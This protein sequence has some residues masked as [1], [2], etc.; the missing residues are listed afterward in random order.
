M[1]FY[2]LTR[3]SLSLVVGRA[4]CFTTT[5]CDASHKI[6]VVGATGTTGL[7]AVQGL[8][9]VGYEPHQLKLV[10][11]D[12]TK[13]TI[14]ELKRLGFGIVQADLEKQSKLDDIGEGCNGCYIHSTSSD[15][16]ELD[17]KEVERAKNLCAAIQKSCIQRV[18]YNSAAASKDHGVARI[19][20]K[21]DVE[22]VFQT[23]I[24]NETSNSTFQFTSL[25]A[26]LFMEELWKHYTR[27]QILGGKYPLPVHRRRKIYLVSVRD[28]GRLAGRLLMGETDG[29]ISIMNVAG[30]YLTGPEIAKA[31]E[32]SQHSTCRYVNPRWFT[33]MA[34]WKFKELY[35]QIK[36]LQ[37]SKETTDIEALQSQ[38]PNLLTSFDEFLEET[39]WGNHTR[40]FE[41]FAKPE[42]LDI[43]SS[44]EGQCTKA[45]F[46]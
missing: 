46:E 26:N 3:L 9:D 27:P 37:T 32:R 30:D 17:L 43:S 42:S 8:L 20:Q 24:E 15:T 7:R 44:Q 12:A 39:S 41:D 10:T 45:S 18:V 29:T 6:L 40:V 36:F 14:V 34:R 2:V 22:R 11:R 19:Q 25:R 33:W 4:L 31:F 38:F 28:L 13:P 35:E 23:A 5:S 1:Y 21:H 16:Q